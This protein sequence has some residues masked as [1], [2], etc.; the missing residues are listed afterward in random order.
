VRQVE[1]HPYFRAHAAAETPH[2]IRESRHQQTQLRVVVEIARLIKASARGR[3]RL[4][5][6]DAGQGLQTILFRDQ[7]ERPQRPLLLDS[8]DLR[9]PDVVAATDFRCVELEADP[10]PV[11]DESVDVVVWNRDLVA[12]KN[13]ANALREVRRV[14]EPGGI[15][16]LTVP[17]LAALHNRFLL[18]AGFQPTTLH[19]AGDHVRGFALSSMTR[20]LRGPVGLS[21]RQIVGVGLQPLTSGVLPW[22]VR[23]LSHTVLWL[24]EK[25][26]RGV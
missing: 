12:L 19:I 25:D 7:L 15:F 3:S 26:D 11:A 22:P 21:V 6:I 5:Q 8:V 17:N 18:L 24:L 23:G 10:F 1:A 13:A 14:L 20:F 4:L 16:I 9:H 2:S